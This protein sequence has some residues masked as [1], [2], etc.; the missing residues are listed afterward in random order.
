MV[1]FESPAD[2]PPR[3]DHNMDDGLDR[4]KC[5]STRDVERDEENKEVTHDA[6]AKLI[7][8]EKEPANTELEGL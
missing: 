8:D 1:S 7:N 3:I 2:T 6:V 5:H 4:D